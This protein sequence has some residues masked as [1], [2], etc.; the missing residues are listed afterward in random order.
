MEGGMLQRNRNE[1]DFKW[2]LITKINHERKIIINL[3]RGGNSFEANKTC[4]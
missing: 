2:L 4:N 3:T 1:S